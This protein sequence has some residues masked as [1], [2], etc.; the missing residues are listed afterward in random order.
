MIHNN[1]VILS[2][3]L[4]VMASV[5]FLSFACSPAPYRMKRAERLYRQGQFYHARG[6]QE[7]AIKKFEESI[8][9]SEMV[10]FKPGIANNLNEMAIIHTRNQAF[11]KARDLLNQCLDIYK[12]LN[13]PSEVSKTLNNIALSYE[14]EGDFPKAIATYE[15][16]LAWDKKTDNHIGMGLT[17]SRI[18]Y[19]Y[20]R[21]LNDTDKAHSKFMESIPYFEQAIEAFWETGTTSGMAKALHNL[22]FVYERYLGKQEEALLKYE[23][24]L[25]LARES[26]SKGLA[27]AVLDDI[28]AIHASKRQFEKAREALNESA[29]LYQ[30]LHMATQASRALKNAALACVMNNDYQAAITQYEASVQWHKKIKDD[31]GTAVALNSMGLLYKEHLNRPEDANAKFMEALQILRK[32]GNET[33]IQIVE[34]NLTPEHPS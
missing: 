16:L 32:L 29:R 12:E 21:K 15:E 3:A 18:G 34:K 11:A 28:A 2:I 20:S 10:D 5:F 25:P 13:M 14:Q 9:L 22:G 6:N 33:Y 31:L 17:A 8:A 23:E 4:L 27:A 26:Q 19:I 1:K 30:E 24:A 7:K